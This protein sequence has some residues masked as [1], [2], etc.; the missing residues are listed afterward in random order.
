MTDPR[1]TIEQAA[2]KAG[3]AM[4]GFSRLGRLREREEFYSRWLD[5]NRH[6]SMAYLARDPQRRF[7]PQV[8]D[9]RFRSVVSLGW[10]YAPP[11]APTVD[12][13]AELRGRIA[14]Y[15]LGRDYHDYVLKAARVVAGAIE[16]LRPG[17]VTRAYVDTGPVFEREWAARGRIGWFG[18]NT[19]L[20]NRDRG[21]YFFLAEI[22]TD[23]EFDAPEEP[24]RDHCGTCRR[25]LD[26]C[27]THALEDGYLMEPRACISYLTIENRGA[28]PGGLRSKIGMWLF[29]CDICQQVCPW[30]EPGSPDAD[31]QL[32]P[33]LPDL[34]ALDDEGFGRRFTRS[35]IKRARRRGLLRNAAV[36]LGN[37]GNRD[38]VPVLAQVM[39]REP[40]PLVRGHTAWALGE[41]GGPVA[42]RALEQARRGDP[43]AS[44]K[45]EVD[46]ALGRISA[47]RLSN[48]ARQ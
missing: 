20:L 38:A 9:P 28:I 19:M 42:Q 2:E 14:A 43:D 23:L 3:F 18:K 25:C 1:R 12:W 45:E 21:S 48:G 35:A 6:G 44:V 39:A 29:G 40:E 32:M 13:R 11:P 10:P 27:P 8:I 17:A 4:V 33:Y 30:N 24:Y 26:L 46:A 41:L 5:E 36:V 22:F 16:S 7:D 34:L 47:G 15:A 31:N 37:T